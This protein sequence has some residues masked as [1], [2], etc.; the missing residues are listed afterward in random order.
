MTEKTVLNYERYM[1]N[2]EFHRISYV[3]DDYIR[4]INKHWVNNVKIADATN[5][6]VFRKQLIIDCFYACKIIAILVHPIAPEGCEMFREYLCLGE[7]LWD[8]NYI[9]EPISAYVEDIN[10]HQLKFLEPRVDFFKKHDC[11]FSDIR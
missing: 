10:S 6:T 1:Y 2:Q 7:K 5:N 11:Q 9:L 3:L 8:W 4:S